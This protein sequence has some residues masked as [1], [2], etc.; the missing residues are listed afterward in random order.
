L[1]AS[2]IWKKETKD[3]PAHQVVAT[4]RSIGINHFSTSLHFRAKGLANVQRVPLATRT[5]PMLA[6]RGF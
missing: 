3:R 5:S 4:L 2:V 6:S 1:V